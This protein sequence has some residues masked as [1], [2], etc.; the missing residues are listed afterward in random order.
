MTVKRF[1]TDKRE[2]ENDYG[3]KQKEKDKT[4][5]WVCTESDGK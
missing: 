5:H 3:C 1:K 2:R 4:K